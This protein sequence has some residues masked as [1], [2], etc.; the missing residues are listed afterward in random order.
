[1]ITGAYI[2]RRFAKSSYHLAVLQGIK[3]YHQRFKFYKKTSY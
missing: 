1:M 2:A 3:H